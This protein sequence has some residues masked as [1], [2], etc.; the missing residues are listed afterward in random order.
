MR[1]Q[2]CSKLSR[3]SALVRQRAALHTYCR[4]AQH[5]PNGA[6]PIE[7]QLRALEQLR[8]NLLSNVAHE[9]RTP[10]SGIL[11]YGELLEEELN[12]RLNDEQRSFMHQILSEGYHL[13]DL[14]NTMLDMSQLAT[15]TLELDRQPLSLELLVQQVCEQ[16]RK[17]ASPKEI[18]L[19]CMVENPLPYVYADPSRAFQVLGHLLT[20]ALKFTPVGGTVTLSARL[21]PADGRPMVRV[22]VTDSGIGINPEQLPM[23]FTSFFQA[24]P[25]ATRAFGGLGLGLSLSKNLIELQGGHI[26]AQSI[27]GEGSTFGFTLPVWQESDEVLK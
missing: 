22:E 12:E 7:Q 13:R 2:F 23:L 19:S 18:L 16:Y 27:P 21:E 10:L 15:G 17:L 11:G 25:S 20:N 24:D 14:I 5:E 9:L 6:I 1:S 4:N 26:W 3:L 8:R